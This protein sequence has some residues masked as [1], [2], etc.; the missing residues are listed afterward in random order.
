MLYVFFKDLV[1]IERKF[2]L[3]ITHNDF[4]SKTEGEYY[5]VTSGRATTFHTSALAKGPLA[6]QALFS[7]FFVLGII[8]LSFVFVSYCLI[9][10]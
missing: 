8:S 10:D 5:T 6:S 4:L 9:M 3:H 2:D 1:K 7:S